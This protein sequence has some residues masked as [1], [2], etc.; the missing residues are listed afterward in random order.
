[1]DATAIGQKLRELS[2]SA[3]SSCICVFSSEVGPVLSGWQTGN[4]CRAELLRDRGCVTMKQVG[5]KA[6]TGC[7]RKST[8]S[9]Y[10]NTSQPHRNVTDKYHFR[11]HDSIYMFA[12]EYRAV[13]TSAYRHLNGTEYRPL[14]A[15]RKGECCCHQCPLVQ[16]LPDMVQQST[17]MMQQSTAIMMK[18]TQY[19]QGI[20]HENCIMSM[21]P[22]IRMKWDMFYSYVRSTLY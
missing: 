10:K 19:V 14:M 18:Q 8:P 22:H 1:M 15:E 5:K 7:V 20:G 11:H 4:G 12:L 3:S 16:T 21:Y 2:L 6:S 9:K 13:N 17:S